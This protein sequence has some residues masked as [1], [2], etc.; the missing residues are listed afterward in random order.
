MIRALWATFGVALT[1]EMVA[2][3]AGWPIYVSAA[4]LAGQTLFQSGLLLG[5]WLTIRGDV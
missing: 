2:L 1:V 4:A 3:A 5:A